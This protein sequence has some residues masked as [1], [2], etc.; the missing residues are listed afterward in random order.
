MVLFAYAHA[1]WCPVPAYAAI[2]GLALGE[3]WAGYGDM[4]CAVLTY[5]AMRCHYIVLCVK[6]LLAHDTMQ[7]PCMVFCGSRYRLSVS[8]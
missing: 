7:C 1:M 4:Q 6:C 5:S 2:P 3:Y 8:Y